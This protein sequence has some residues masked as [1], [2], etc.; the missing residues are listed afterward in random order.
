MLATVLALIIILL[1]MAYCYLKCDALT[2]F[3]TLISGVLGFIVAFAYYESLGGWMLGMGYGGQWAMPLVYVLLFVITFAVMRTVGDQ[4][5]GS[6]IELGDLAKRITAVICGLLLGVIISGVVLISLSLAPLAAKWP[7]PR[8]AESGLDASSL[9]SAKKPLVN[10]DGFVAG[11]FGWISKGSL[12]SG[13]SFAVYHDDYIS[14]IRMNRLKV[15]DGIYSVAGKDSI[16][17]P[18]KGVRKL[19]GDNDN[20]TVVRMELRDSDIKKGGAKDPDRNV[21]FTLSQVRLVCKKKGQGQTDTRGAGQV[22][23]P[24]GRVVTRKRLDNK[25]ENK[26]LTGPMTGRFF[27]KRN[28]DEMITVPSGDFKAGKARLD[29]AFDVPSGMEPVLLAFK[30]NAVTKVPAS[31]PASDENEELLRTGGQSA[32]ESGAGSSGPSDPNGY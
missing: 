30:Q 1:S 27:E 19:D 11:L 29:I 20:L 25:A 22:V 8:F 32:T 18:K 10:A 6:G 16:A 14:E 15:K 13:K 5:L 28:L 24:E 23:Y 21:S 3:A 7:Y 17:V 4:V 2:S 26:P 9:R 31:V 12:S